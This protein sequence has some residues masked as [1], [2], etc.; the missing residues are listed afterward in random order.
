MVSSQVVIGKTP[1]H[2][3]KGWTPSTGNSIFSSRG[4]DYSTW[5]AQQR[6]ALNAP[7]EEEPTQAEARPAPRL[8]WLCPS[9]KDGKWRSALEYK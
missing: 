4:G 8:D 6:H 1:I 3:L 9:P 5:R 2:W 7:Q